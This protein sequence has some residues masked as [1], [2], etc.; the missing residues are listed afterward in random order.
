MSRYESVFSFIFIPSSR[1]AEGSFLT[2]SRNSFLYKLTFRYLAVLL[3][4]IILD[5][6]SP[7]TCV[8]RTYYTC[9]T[10]N[11]RS[12]QIDDY[13]Q[14]RTVS[15]RHWKCGKF[16]I[17]EFSVC[18]VGNDSSVN[19]SRC[20]A[21]RENY[22]EAINEEKISN[23]TKCERARVNFELYRRSNFRFTK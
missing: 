7:L 16:K 3:L 15:A 6:N 11:A 14:E 13:C 18:V 22:R 19:R 9:I 1:G 8:T 2:L 12:R 17:L 20:H 10:R 5:S 21:K 23:P 4:Q